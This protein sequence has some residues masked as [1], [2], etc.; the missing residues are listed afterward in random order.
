MKRKRV[1][2]RAIGDNRYA[3]G[4]F[5]WLRVRALERPDN[6]VYEICVRFKGRDMRTTVSKGNKPALEFRIGAWP[7]AM[8][9][10]FNT[11]LHHWEGK[12]L[13]TV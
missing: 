5:R 10:D 11:V 9:V 3:G 12:D 1:Y 13:W 4:T 6:G 7:N 2:V 8:P